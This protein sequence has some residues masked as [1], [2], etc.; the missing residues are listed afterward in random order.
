M[1]EAEPVDVRS[2]IAWLWLGVC[3]AIL[4]SS[5]LGLPR[6]SGVGE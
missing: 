1:R 6:F 3:A 4:T 2:V 5:T